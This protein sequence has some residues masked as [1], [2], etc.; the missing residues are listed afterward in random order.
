MDESACWPRAAKIADRLVCFS[1]SVIYRFAG[2]GRQELKTLTGIE[3]TPSEIDESL[4][5]PLLYI[6]ELIKEFLPAFEASPEIFTLYNELLSEINVSN[7]EILLRQ[8]ERSVMQVLGYLPDTFVDADLGK[9]VYAE[10]YYLFKA[11]RGFISCESETSNAIEGRLI[12]LWNAG[13]YRQSTVRHLA[14]TIMRC[15][16]DF[17]L[18]GKRL[19]SRDIYLQLNSG[20]NHGNNTRR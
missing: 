7:Y 16:I 6:N 19:K 3:G 15:I 17:N 14:K 5:M 4:Y 18:Q 11:S 10:L 13:D 12:N 2:A 20:H 8:F 1:R 9:P